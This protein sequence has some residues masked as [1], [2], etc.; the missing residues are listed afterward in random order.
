MSENVVVS[1]GRHVTGEAGL[2]QRPVARLF[3]YKVSEPPA[4]RRGILLGFLIAISTT[5][6]M[7][8]TATNKKAIRFIRFLLNQEDLIG[9]AVVAIFMFPPA[10]FRMGV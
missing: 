4:A 10:R 7:V 3:A 1:F 5:P 6:A 2:A 8:A 9:K